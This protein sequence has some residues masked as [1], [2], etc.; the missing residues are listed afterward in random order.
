MLRDRTLNVALLLLVIMVVLPGG[1]LQSQQK[2]DGFTLDRAR[3]ILHDAY[4]GVKKHY[5]DPKY[6]GLDINA[7]FHEYD[8]K[9]KNAPNLSAAF[10]LVAGF[11]DGLNDS[12]TFFEPP[13]R[14]YRVDYGFRIPIFGDNCFITQ[15]RPGTDAEN[16]LHKG[17]RIIT[18]NS[19]NVNRAD[20]WKM[21]YY[22]NGLAQQKA[23]LLDV[24]SPEGQ[25]EKLTV[26]AKVRELKRVLDFTGSDGGTDI[27][28]TVREGENYDH[29][30]RQRYY[31]FENVGVMVW[32][33]PDFLIDEEGVDHLMGLARKH[34]ALVLDLRGNPGGYIIRLE[35]MLGSVFDHDIKVADRVG[36]KELKPE[37]AKTRG[38]NVFSGK[39]IVLVDSDSASAAELFA[40]VIQLEKRG[41]IVGDRSS[42]SVMEALRY[43]YAQGTDT[44]IFYSFSIT[45][46]DLIMKD[47]KSLEHAGVTPDE[48]IIPTA[49]DLEMGKDPALARAMELAGMNIEPAAA[50]KLFPFEWL[51]N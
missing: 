15:V 10:G 46:A 1:E 37:M 40:R 7:R 36:R 19:Y 41:T 34:K 26:D 30:V 51:P 17:D 22:F 9:I 28:D 6:H 3:E 42:G 43:G 39:L 50:G 14:P 35:R 4:D 32:K 48:T 23:S 18:Y 5:Y 12:H 8:E 16:K 20:L 47:G 49:K 13:A 11:L 27:W 2:M 24:F 25:E 44:K 45:E 29:L 38:S 31:E 21:N 33:M